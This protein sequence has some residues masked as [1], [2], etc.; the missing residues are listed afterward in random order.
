MEKDHNDKNVQAFSKTAI[1]KQ[2]M[3]FC[4]LA[5]LINNGPFA[6][7]VTDINGSIEYVNNSFIKLTGFKTEEILGKSTSIL[8]SGKTDPLIYKKL[9]K[10]IKKGET[11]KDVN[12]ITVVHEHYNN[13][14]EKRI[15]EIMA[16]PLFDENNDF[17]GI[18][19][20]WR[21]I[22]ARIVQENKLIE[23][24]SNLKA[25]INS[26]DQS[27]ILLDKDNRILC[28]N[29]NFRK[30]V[31]KR[32]SLKVS[33]G[34]LFDSFIPKTDLD[35]LSK[36]L[37]KAYVGKSILKEIQVDNI[38]YEYYFNP[39][40]NHDGKY[41][42][43]SICYRD[44][45]ERKKAQAVI[46]HMAYNDILTD[47]PNRRLFDD[48]L[49]IALAQ[50]ER[51]NHKLAVLLLDFDYFK[52]INDTF[53][54]AAGDMLL[55]SVASRIS[56][57]LRASDTLARLGGDEFI[58]LAPSINNFDMVD[59][60]AK[61]ILDQFKRPY[62]IRNNE[63]NITASIGVSIYPDDAKDSLELLKNADTAMYNAK[64]EGR[65]KYK[66]FTKTMNGN[67]LQRFKMEM[68]MHHALH[69]AQ[70][71][72]Y[73]QP[74]HETKTNKVVAVEALLRWLHPDLGMILPERFISI[75]EETGL[76]IP[77]GEWLIETVCRQNRQWIDDGHDPLK[78]AINLSARQLREPDLADF[79]KKSLK[80][81]N[82]DHTNF[83]IEITET[84]MMEEGSPAIDTLTKLTEMGIEISLDDF[85]TGYSSLGYLKQFPIEFLKIDRSFIKD[86]ID[87]EAD[88]RIVRAILSMAHSLK[89]K[90][91]A[92]GVES[93]EQLQYLKWLGCDQVQGFLLSHPVSKKNIHNIIK[94]SENKE[95][96]I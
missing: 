76:I 64:N 27:I 87:N 23:S 25:I 21:D 6:F 54:H 59:R 82:L 20:S 39:V 10:K 1:D 43:V 53:G 55:K 18:V 80:D 83:S 68:G 8:K 7:M 5:C 49:K 79:I 63:L 84:I 67:V 71:Q 36:Y 17:Q 15:I 32:F 89:K 48:R 26:G 86:S 93:E 28:F 94:E 69:N 42:G 30:E 45:S 95:K 19:E 9:C 57:I 50:A 96:S 13:L 85:G 75:A 65:Y 77:I 2:K 70:F 51:E 12:P 90:V 78:I 41:N 92:E 66:F 33:I 58:I 14:S 72:V 60:I 73:Y 38:W 16:S 22:T 4:K 29:E 44:I 46:E 24:E 35:I 52:R 3:Y 91:V 47:I 61:K 81:N 88:A 40:I 56:G 74:I 34:D 11:W 62:F 37:N 31:N